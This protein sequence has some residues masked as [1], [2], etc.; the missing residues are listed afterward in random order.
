[1]IRRFRK[2]AQTRAG[3]SSWT[4]G[5]LGTAS[6]CFMTL[7][8]SPWP[9]APTCRPIVPCQ[10]VLKQSVICSQSATHEPWRI[11]VQRVF[12]GVL[13]ELEQTVESVTVAEIAA[14]HDRVEAVGGCGCGS[15]IAYRAS[16]CPL[17]LDGNRSS[18]AAEA[19]SSWLHDRLRT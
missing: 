6:R 12:D 9:S 8:Q 14:Y 5:M 7:W 19:A 16:R 10:K 18:P 13:Q 2:A 11:T 17:N 4:P 1:M 3:E 15:R